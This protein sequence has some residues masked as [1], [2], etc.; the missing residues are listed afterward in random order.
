MTP[1]ED[2]P[3][4]VE[5]LTTARL[6]KKGNSPCPKPIVTRLRLTREPLLPCCK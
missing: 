4:P 1:P 6:G 2:M 5:Y 3:L